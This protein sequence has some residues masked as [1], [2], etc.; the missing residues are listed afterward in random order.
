M[1]SIELGGNLG[2]G[3]LFGN[4]ETQGVL[5]GS[6]TADV[7]FNNFDEFGLAFEFFYAQKLERFLP[8]DRAGRFY[9]FAKGFSANM[10][11]NQDLKSTVFVEEWIGLLVL[12]SHTFADQSEWDFGLSFAANIGITLGSRE[13]SHWKLS[14]GAKIG[15]TFTKSTPGIYRVE[16][17]A[18]YY[19]KMK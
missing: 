16:L 4:F 10:N 8:E 3:E 19:F 13:K 17:G 1:K 5:S 14:A 6:L 11:L 7:S 9:P 2:G 18:A 15:E 12:N